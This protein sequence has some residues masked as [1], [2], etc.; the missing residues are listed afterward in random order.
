M[1]G[2]HPEFTG[3]YTYVSGSGSRIS[4]DLTSP[5]PR[6]SP[7]SRSTSVGARL[8][9][10]GGGVEPIQRSAAAAWSFAEAGAAGEQ[11]GLGAVHHLDLG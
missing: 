10:R 2:W 11:D 5:W 9:P 3:A 6:C 1:A 7:R 8:S 4:G